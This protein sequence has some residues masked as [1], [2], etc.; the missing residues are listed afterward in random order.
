MGLFGLFEKKDK[1]NRAKKRA[2]KEFVEQKKREEALRNEEEI[3]RWK[4]ERSIL[5]EHE[6]P[7]FLAVPDYDLSAGF[8]FSSKEYVC[9]VSMAINRKNGEVVE[10]SRAY[11][12]DS[13][14]IEKA[15]HDVIA[16]EKML[17]PE[18]LGI[19]SLPTLFTNFRMVKPVADVCSIDDLPRNH[20]ILTLKPYTPTGR[21]A[22]YPVTIGVSSYKETMSASNGSHGSVSYL[23]DGSIGKAQ[24]HF[25][26]DHIYYGAHFKIINGEIALNVLTYS[27]DPSS[28][29]KIELYR[30]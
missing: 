4:E 2:M 6:M 7:P 1:S 30:A 28:G 25:W 14:A 12:A 27:D 16:L 17:S 15:K 22:R 20:V 13:E 5:K 26:K 29:K 10:Q 24:F 23:R 18:K 9:F 19:A 21:D 8:P 11:Y 3:K